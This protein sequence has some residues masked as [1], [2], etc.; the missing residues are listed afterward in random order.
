[1]SKNNEKLGSLPGNKPS[2]TDPTDDTTSQPNPLKKGVTVGRN[3]IVKQATHSTIES[4][5][6]NIEDFKNG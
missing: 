6:P 1:M 3:P 5:R 4:L 2:N